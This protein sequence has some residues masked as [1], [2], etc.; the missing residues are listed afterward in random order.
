MQLLVFSPT[1]RYQLAKNK[2]LA[3]T[4]FQSIRQ[5]LT[6]LKPE[7]VSKYHVRS[8]GLFGSIVRDDFTESSDIDIP[9]SPD[10]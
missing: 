7:L 1:T 3:M 9:A 8:M 4:N 2:L 6:H 5:I 10:L